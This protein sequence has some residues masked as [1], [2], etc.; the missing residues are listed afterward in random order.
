[1]YQGTPAAS[2]PLSPVDQL[3]PA[4]SQP[5]GVVFQRTAC[6]S[7]GAW[8]GPCSVT[9]WSL[10]AGR[11]GGHQGF[12]PPPASPP[13]PSHRGPTGARGSPVQGQ[14]EVGL[15]GA[16]RHPGPVR[17]Q[18]HAWRWVSPQRC[19]NQRQATAPTQHNGGL[20]WGSGAEAPSLPLCPAGEGPGLLLPAPGEQ[21]GAGGSWAAATEH[22]P[23]LGSRRLPLL[24]GALEAWGA[25]PLLLSPPREKPT[26]ATET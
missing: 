25:L 1:M 19:W 15:E 17:P 9:Y 16:L 13:H 26:G 22:R 23:A 6:L 2:Q 11:E 10:R 21:T 24:A 20:G 8:R 5:M 7:T 12:V 14:G 18:L 3:C 4:A